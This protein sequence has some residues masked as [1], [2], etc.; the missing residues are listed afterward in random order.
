MGENEETLV[1]VKPRNEDI[2]YYVF[3]YLCELLNRD[4]IEYTKSKTNPVICPPEKIVSEHYRDLRF[5]DGEI[6]RDTIE[7]YKNGTIFLQT[8]SG[9]DII[10]GVRKNIGNTAPERAEDWTVRGYFRRDSLENALK[11]KRYLN[12]VIHASSD[13]SEAK[14]ELGLWNDFLD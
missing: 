4:K 8:Y 3:D 1:F 12:N 5:F 2:A 14:R 11:Q 6:F 9:E 13:A 7:V 10:S